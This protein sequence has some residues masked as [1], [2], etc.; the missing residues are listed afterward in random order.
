MGLSVFSKLD[1]VCYI[2]SIAKATS[3]KFGAQICSKKFLSPKVALYCYKS[4]IQPCMEYCSC[5]CVNTSSCYLIMRDK[6]KKLVF[7]TVVSL[8]VFALEP[9]PYHQNVASFSLSQTYYYFCRFSFELAGFFQ[10]PHS[11]GTPTFYS[12]RQHDFCATILRFYKYIYVNSYFLRK[13]KLWNPLP[14]KHF[15]LTFDL[16]CRVN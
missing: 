10:L 8:L 5:V 13:T 2:V 16:K 7:S 3:K 11:C 9:L 14:A 6:L 15:P 12:D 1:W 4:T